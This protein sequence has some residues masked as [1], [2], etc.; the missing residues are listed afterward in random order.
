[1]DSS[2]GALK[3]GQAT[4][5]GDITAGLGLCSSDAVLSNAAAVW[6][7]VPMSGSSDMVFSGSAG[8]FATVLFSGEAGAEFFAT[9]LRMG[10]VEHFDGSANMLSSM[11]GLFTPLWRFSGESSFVFGAGC[12]RIVPIVW[13]AAIIVDFLD[14][15]TYPMIVVTEAVEPIPT[16]TI[17]VQAF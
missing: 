7:T 15:P 3:V 17:S 6:A 4:L 1:V 10:G 9:T 2:L 16:N 13:G 14:E 11:S 5:A 12:T 8:F